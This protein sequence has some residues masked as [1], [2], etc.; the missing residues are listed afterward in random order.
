MREN[1]PWG[2]YETIEEHYYT[3]H[4]RTGFKVKK[5]GV[6]SHKRLSLQKHRQR[7]EHWVILTGKAKVRIGD[8]EHILFRNQSVYIPTGT[9]HRIEN[10]GD[11]PLEFIEVQIGD[12]LDED[13]I[14]R[15]E[16]DFGRV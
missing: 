13:D 7:S 2:W 9:L 10:V 1:R 16:D 14:E 4:H 11:E 12:Y 15:I 8:D 5:I 6:H 3:E